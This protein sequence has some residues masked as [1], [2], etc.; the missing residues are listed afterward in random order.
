MENVKPMTNDKQTNSTTKQPIV[1]K[2]IQQPV[3]SPKI[4]ANNPVIKK[5]L[6]QKPRPIPKQIQKS[7]NPIKSQIKPTSITANSVQPKQATKPTPTNPKQPIQKSKIQIPKKSILEKI[8]TA[9]RKIV[10]KIKP[11]LKILITIFLVT[12][13][14]TISVIGFTKIKQKTSNQIIENETIKNSTIK[15]ITE[16]NKTKQSKEENIQIKESP[17]LIQ[18]TEFKSYTLTTNYTEENY[19]LQK[20]G[21]ALNL[22][23]TIVENFRE[24]LKDFHLPIFLQ[25]KD[26][27]SER[28][29]QI[30]FVNENLRLIEFS[31]DDYLNGTETYGFELDKN[32]ELLKYEIQFDE[33]I[34]WENLA[35]ERI[36]IL[37]ETYEINEV[38]ESKNEI[39]LFK[40]PFKFI[41][42]ENEIVQIKTPTKNNNISTFLVSSDAV[43]INLGNETTEILDIGETYYGED[44]YITIGDIFYSN[45]EK[46]GLVEIT[47]SP[48]RIFLMGNNVENSSEAI[49]GLDLEFLTEEE[50]LSS[51]SISWKTKEESF[52]TS[53]THLNLPY[54]DTMELSMSDR[55]VDEDTKYYWQVHLNTKTQNYNWQESDKF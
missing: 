10:E 47:I 38:E 3:Q 40:N 22:N 36:T 24:N 1:Q 39:E 51:I 54:F 45:V 37:G 13:I 42:K 27:S 17:K 26:F 49:D 6:A 50:K 52:L 16:E 46:L 35:G 30:L 32:T 8:K 11:I 43:I 12:I 28:S 23:E 31:D 21:Q 55:M 7:A 20:K 48:E 4:S 33:P 18:K 44:F 29:D 34:A 14:L 19:I 5:Q 15:D 53:R 41:L 9:R 2:P 25:T